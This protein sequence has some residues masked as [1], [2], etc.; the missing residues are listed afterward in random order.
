MLFNQNDILQL[1]L[2]DALVALVFKMVNFWSFIVNHVKGF[3]SQILMKQRVLLVIVNILCVQ[4]NEFS[5]T[6]EGHETQTKLKLTIQAYIWV[7]KKPLIG[8]FYGLYTNQN[9]L[10]NC[11][12]TKDLQLA[13]NISMQFKIQLQNLSSF[14]SETR[15]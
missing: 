11:R 10:L 3:Y 4:K 9:K 12:L 15:V 6:A 2:S 13:S 1:T 14:G 8:G 5:G 7:P